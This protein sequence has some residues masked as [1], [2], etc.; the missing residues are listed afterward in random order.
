MKGTIH[1]SIEKLVTE[2]FGEEKWY[3]CLASVGLDE[4]HVFMLN[5]DVDEKLTMDLLTKMPAVL[6]ISFQQVCDAFGEY[7][8]NAYVPKIYFGYIEGYKN[9]K[10]FLLAMDEI[11]DTVTKEIPNAHPPRFDYVD[12]GDTIIVTYKSS[13]GLIDLYISLVKGVGIYFKQ[14]LDVKKLSDT[15]VEIKFC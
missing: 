5:E 12:N 14:M 10:D 4:D 6:G 3:E 9:A 8:V 1:K 13:R 2:K 7:W 15:E 11:H